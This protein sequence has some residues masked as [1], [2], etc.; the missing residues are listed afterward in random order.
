MSA[1]L[2]AL[3]SLRYNGGL[4]TRPDIV[5]AGLLLY[6]FATFAEDYG[7]QASQ[8][9]QVPPVAQQLVREGDF[10]IKLAAAGKLIAPRSKG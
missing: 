2:I 9:Q 6:P 8:A 3:S 7:S 5:A 4:I 1:M 10:A